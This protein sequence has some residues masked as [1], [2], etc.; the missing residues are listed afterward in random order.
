MKR[1]NE[2]TKIAEI[3]R[4]VK[5]PSKENIKIPTQVMK[6]LEEIKKNNKKR[7]EILD[8]IDK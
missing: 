5:L 2:T 6:D 8:S 1:I 7:Q 3:K 4:M